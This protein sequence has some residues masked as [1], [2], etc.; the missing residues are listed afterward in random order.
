[1]LDYNRA[2]PKY[3]GL[4]RFHVQEKDIPIHHLGSI[5]I[6][7]KMSVH[8]ERLVA[9]ESDQTLPEVSSLE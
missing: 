5:L 7:I 8:K 2:G 1:M 9:H 3:L 4:V 6:D